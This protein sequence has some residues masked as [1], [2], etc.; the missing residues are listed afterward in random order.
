MRILIVSYFFR[1]DLRPGSFRTSALVDA[2]R[3]LVPAG[4]QIDVVTTLSAR[5]DLPASDVSLTEQQAGLCI[6]RIALPKRQMSMIDQT[7]AFLAFSC[8]ARRRVADRKYDLVF[9]TSGRLMTAVLGA[10]IAKGKGAKLYLDIRD[11]FVENIDEMLPRKIRWIVKPI[12]SQLEKWAI[13]RAAKVNLVS[14]GFSEY[15]TKRYPL[16]RFSY[17]TNGI[18][19]EFLAVAPTETS[20]PMLQMRDKMLT[21]LYAGNLGDGQGLHRIIPRLAKRMESRVQFVVIGDGNSK[22][23]LVE[24]LTSASVTNV[25]LIPPVNREE[26][27]KAYRV[28]DVLFLHLNDYAA[29]KKVLP[30]KLFE[31]GALG[32]P[33]WAG[34]AGYPAKFVRSE[35]RNAAVFSPCDVEDAIQAFANLRLQDLPRPE[36]IAKYSRSNISQQLAGDIL[37]LVKSVPV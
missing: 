32:K 2:L 15:F 6:F 30:S 12:F 7:I 3:D 5:Y 4:S 10:W 35:I 23:A 18:D 20:R 13:E 37:A 9:A 11:I 34:V 31:Y 17:L 22:R 25:K 26:L 14:E 36:F 29:F 19:D 8:G 16:L 1:P 33:V 28:A 27:L 21:V 24:A